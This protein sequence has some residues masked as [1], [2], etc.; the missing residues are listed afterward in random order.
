MAS[1]TIRAVLALAATWC[2]ACK[3][4][5]ARPHEPAVV[6]H[7]GPDRPTLVESLGLETLGGVF[8][9]LLETGAP[10]PARSE[11]VFSTA[12]DDQGQIEVHAFAGPAATTRDARLLGHYIVSGIPP[13]PRGQPKIRVRF[14][15]ATDGR[16]A[17]SAIDLASPSARLVVVSPTD[18][19]PALKT[20][21]AS[22]LE[23]RQPNN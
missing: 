12:E 13:A 19:V 22:P 7:S 20:A 3:T 21:L 16:L 11:Q 10:L 23:R 4:S 6:E 18:S 2:F 14:D 9:P 8:T 17:I 5:T 1:T 15:V